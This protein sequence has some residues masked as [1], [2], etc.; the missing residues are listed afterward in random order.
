M[1]HMGNTR[2]EITNNGFSV[3]KD[4]IKR[5]EKYVYLASFLFYDEKSLTC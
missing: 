4:I 3:L 1:V 5:A 2:I